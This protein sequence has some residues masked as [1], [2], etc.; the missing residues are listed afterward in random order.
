[1]DEDPVMGI[2]VYEHAEEALLRYFKLAKTHTETLMHLWHILNIR[3]FLEDEDLALSNKEE[4]LQLCSEISSR[5]VLRDKI[6]AVMDSPEDERFFYAN[7]MASRLEID[8]TMK[9]YKTI[10]KDPVKNQGY[11]AKVYRNPD[12]AKELIALIEKTLPLE[13]MASGMGNYLF[14]PTYMQEC[15]CLDFVLQELRNYPLLGE[16]LVKT[17]LLSPV[18]RNRNGACKIIDAWF[19]KIG[20]PVAEYS[21][22]LYDTLKSVSDG[23]INT[24]TKKRMI[25]LVEGERLTE[26]D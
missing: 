19:E 12:Y 21:P 2:S 17:T 23:E 15:G 13:K 7:N 3:T 24:D 6:L 4:L 20:Q 5:Q 1:M 26:E 16:L 25:K 11:F 18:M 22:T 14:S 9:V 10:K 8:V